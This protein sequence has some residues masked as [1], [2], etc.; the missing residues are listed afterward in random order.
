MWE[1]NTSKNI[2]YTY[3]TQTPIYVGEQEINANRLRYYK[4]HDVYFVTV[5][6]FGK[7]VIKKM[8]IKQ[9]N[10]RTFYERMTSVDL[11]KQLDKSK[12]NWEN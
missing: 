6:Q 4:D 8:V 11:P 7:Q 5:S 2:S 10:E 12:S 9:T 3:S 1:Q